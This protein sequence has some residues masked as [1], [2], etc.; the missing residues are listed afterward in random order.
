MSLPQSLPQALPTPQSIDYDAA[1]KDMLLQSFT[2]YWRG[3]VHPDLF[4]D[5]VYRIFHRKQ[6]V[7]AN[8]AAYVRD[9]VEVRGHPIQ[10]VLSNLTFFGQVLWEFVDKNLGQSLAK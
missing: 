2:H 4:V 3:R 9:E 10:E 7:I 1:V 5:N 8:L 6:K